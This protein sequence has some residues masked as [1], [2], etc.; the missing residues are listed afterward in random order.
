[1]KLYANWSYEDYP[2]SGSR[3][4]AQRRVRR[5]ECVGVSELRRS[6]RAVGERWECERRA[7]PF[8]GAR[9]ERRGVRGREGVAPV[10]ARCEVARRGVRMIGRGALEVGAGLGVTVP[11]AKGTRIARARTRRQRRAPR[12]NGRRS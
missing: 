7:V 3:E 8:V 1:M 2:L 5:R 12:G 11:G 9:C 6:A 10:C 4:P